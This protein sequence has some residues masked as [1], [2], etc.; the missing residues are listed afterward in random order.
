MSKQTIL[1]D[2]DDTLIYCNKFFDSVIDRFADQMKTWFQGY[3]LSV[4][5]LKRKQAQIDLERVML[6]GFSPDHFPQSFVD[7]YEYYSELTGRPKSQEEI[8]RLLALGSSVYSHSIEPYAHMEETL[9]ELQENGHTLH[10]YTGGDPAIQMRKVTEAGLDRYFGDRI[11]ITRHKN[12]EFLNG[13]IR[14]YGLDRRNTWMIGNS[15]RTDILPA[16]KNGIHA[17]F[18][19][20]EREWAYNQVEVDVKP[21][22]AY[23]TLTSLNQIPKT[24]HGYTLSKYASGS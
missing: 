5:E 3:P 17:I 9:N 15:L 12:A 21:S 7:T 2:M 8:G 24:I 4:E 13:L 6:N 23:F 20:A 14:G 18:M 16:L 1:F 22:G 19:P 10:L 11:H